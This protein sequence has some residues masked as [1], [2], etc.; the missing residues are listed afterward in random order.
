MDNYT[1]PTRERGIKMIVYLQGL[2]G[3]N[4]TVEKAGAS[5]DKMSAR[6]RQQTFEV[7]GMYINEG[8]W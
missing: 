5:W 1:E 3:I 8:D 7:Y 6:E 2:T 4:E